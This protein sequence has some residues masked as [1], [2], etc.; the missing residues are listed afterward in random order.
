MKLEKKLYSKD[1]KNNLFINLQFIVLLIYLIKL[2]RK[3]SFNF[4]YL[5]FIILFKF[6]NFI[7]K[8]KLLV[9]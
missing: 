5:F 7:I 4:I 9:K 1:L 2:D 6:K 3:I 8:I